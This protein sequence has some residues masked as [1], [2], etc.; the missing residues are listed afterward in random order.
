M[1]KKPRV[2]LSPAAHAIDNKTKCPGGKCGENIHCN[3]YM[4]I[5]EKRLK[6][7]GFA[8]KRGSAKLTGEKAMKTR[9]KE[10]N[11]WG[12]V[13]YYAAHTN[14]GG[15][16]YSMTMCWPDG[17]SRAKAEVLHKYRKCVANHKV[18]TRRDLYEINQTAMPCLYDE[19]IFHDNAEDCA[20]FH[21]G[22]TDKL[23]EE[24]VQAIC[25]ICDVA[26]KA[27]VTEKAETK[28]ET[29]TK[30]EAAKP[31]AKKTPKAGDTVKLSKGKL[32]LASTGSAAVTRTGTFYLYDGKKV[33]G[34]YR[35]T[36]KKSRV[37]KK[38]VALYVSG[39]V[40]R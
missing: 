6:E 11:K 36:N 7:L 8:V 40:K 14:A 20:W 13:L 16:R 12:A 26:Y 25:E 3:Q 29:A 32:Y 33:N 2:Y 1:A 5:M 18:V 24:T 22:G 19:L 21:N 28:T 4:D 17:A 37:G 15:G 10:A 35:V 23:A 34:R 39:W 9:V 30:T 38:P 27:P 31:A